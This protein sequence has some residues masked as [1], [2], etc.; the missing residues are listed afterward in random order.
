MRPASE[1]SIVGHHY[2]HPE[3]SATG[4]CNEA[5]GQPQTG[6]LAKETLLSVGQEPFCDSF[7]RLTD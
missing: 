7:P 1:I 3:L 6:R 2:C 5:I 4:N